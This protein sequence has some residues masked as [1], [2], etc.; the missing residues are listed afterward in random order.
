MASDLYSTLGVKRSASEKEIRSAFRKLAR[1]YHPDVN[2]GNNEAEAK[3][4]QINAAFEVLSDPDKRKKYDQYGD[5]WMHA[6]QIEEMR[7]RQSAG[8]A[9][10]F[11]GAGGPGGPGGGTFRFST[12]D[13][14]FDLGDIFGAAAGGARSGARGAGGIFGDLFRRGGGG[15]RQRGQDAEADVRVTLEEAYNGARRTIEVRAGEEPCRVCAGSGQI[16]NATC[17]VCRGTGVAAPLRRVEVSVPAGV[18]DGQRIRLSGQ[19]APGGNGA[20]PGDLYLRVTVTSHPRFERKG[21]DLHVE[22][23]IPVTDAALGGEAKVPTLKGKTLALRVPAGTQA[24]KTFRLAG[25]G[26][27]RQGGGFGDLYAKARLVLPDPLTDEQRRLF[28]QLRDSTA[29][30]TSAGSAGSTSASNASGSEAAT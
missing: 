1:Q 26:M 22:V 19:G 21:D 14:G 4:K 6:D 11:G 2:P 8:G 17:H 5:Q 25:Q 7:R 15:G 3:F 16:A 18:K 27:P 30:R 20:A 9:G 28:E 13:E 23:D 12:G 10:G 24:G 29:P